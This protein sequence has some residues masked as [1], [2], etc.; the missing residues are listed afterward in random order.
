MI[1][2]KESTLVK[3]F[4][5]NPVYVTMKETEKIRNGEF[6]VRKPLLNPANFD[7]WLLFC[8]NATKQEKIK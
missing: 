8:S 5:L 4:Q 1:K 6:N 3:G 2:I 7:D